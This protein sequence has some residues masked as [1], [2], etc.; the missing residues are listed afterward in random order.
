MFS[1]AP[2]CG[3]RGRS[4]RTPRGLSCSRVQCAVSTCDDA[5]E[6]DVG[7]RRGRR[8]PWSTPFELSSQPPTRRRLGV[9]AGAGPPE[10]RVP[11]R[12]S[13][14]EPDLD[15]RKRKR[16]RWRCPRRT[17]SEHR[18][19]QNTE[20]CTPFAVRTRHE[21]PRARWRD[22]SRYPSHSHSSIVHC[23]LMHSES[24]D[25]PQDATPACSSVSRAQETR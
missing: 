12:A 5:P 8:W 17:N 1:S 22:T 6:S 25:R 7:R 4:R 16:K 10:L 3:A 18:R 14:R 9:G 13:E 19:T 21:I 24:T 15:R 20:H 23:P 11:W 2:P